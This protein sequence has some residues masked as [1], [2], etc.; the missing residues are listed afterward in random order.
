MK[1]NAIELVDGPFHGTILE[2]SPKIRLGRSPD[3]IGMPDKDEP[4]K[5]RHFYVMDGVDDSDVVGGRATATF[6]RTERK[7]SRKGRGG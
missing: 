7:K 1:V 2:M 5:V 4:A 6:A 3:V